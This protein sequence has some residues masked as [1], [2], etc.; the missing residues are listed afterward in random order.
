[1]YNVF[2]TVYLYNTDVDIFELQN[3]NAFDVVRFA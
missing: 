2:V 3:S 1:M